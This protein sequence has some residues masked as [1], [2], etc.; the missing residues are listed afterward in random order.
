MAKE[1]SPF[2]NL[3]QALVSLIERY[4]PFNIRYFKA[5]VGIMMTLLLSTVLILGWL[6]SRKV[7]EIVTE[8]FNQQQLVLVRH[9]A[10][11]IENS[12]NV[13]K[14]ELMLLSLSPAIQYPESPF[15]DNRMEIAFSSIKHE[16][17]ME[18]RFVEDKSL[19]T[20]HVLENQK[21][22]TEP[23]DTEDKHYVEWARSEKNKDN[24]Y[25]TDVSP[26]QHMD[27]S[28]KLLMKMILPVWQI[29]VNESHPE[30]PDKFF[31]VLIFVID[32][33]KL[34]EG[35]TKGIR[36]GKTGYSWVIDENGTFLYHQEST[37]IGK[38]AFE[39]RKGKKPTISF[40]RI[41]EIQKEKMLK[42]EEGTSWY[43]SGWHRGVE[44]E[45]KKLIA[46][47]P[48]KLANAG[49]RIWSVAVVAPISEVEGAIHDI[50]IR[51]FLL[52]GIVIF[53]IL[54][55][56]VLIIGMMLRWS[57][58]LK[59]EVEEKTKELRKSEEQYRSLVEHAGDIIFT[60]NKEDKLSSMNRY[61][62]NF[63]KKRPEE[64]LGCNII[65]LF[66]DEC[67]ELQMEKIKEV[68]ATNI[69]TQITCPVE[70]NGNRYWLST[71]Y[72]GLLDENG[73]VFSVLGISRDITDRKKMEETSY[74]TEKLASMGTLAAGVA[75]EINN[76]LGIIL[77]FTDM[78]LE[79]A[80]PGSQEHDI[81][82]TMERHGLRAKRV[83]ENLLSFA[84]YSECKEEHVD[85]N[86]SIS[87]VL[88]VVEH[89]LLLNKIS[90]KQQMQDNLPE[91]KGCSE[92]LQQVFFNIMNNAASAMKGGG[93]LTITT[94]IL[95]DN[96]HIEIR[97][98]DTGHGIK[99]EYRR[100]IFDPL[101]TT[102][103]VGE[104][105]GL[106]LSVSYGI[107]TKHGGTIT[108]E[109]KTKEESEETGTTFIITLPAV[110]AGNSQ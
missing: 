72:N 82:T 83:V 32:V 88:T 38:N 66:P 80:D 93:V 13:L 99:K 21:C 23:P 51:Q 9:A 43:I 97:F 25:L 30:A 57:G 20:H 14:R 62:Y 61:G 33:N 47:S 31:G 54:S 22:H 40:A 24:I 12:L 94:R 50:Q 100:K 2:L 101:F 10:S 105:T 92:E 26:V 37:F 77:G 3:R 34:I 53:A 75:H 29:S 64:I 109:T 79:K 76:P 95:S 81:L 58:S 36:S 15:M 16:G 52:E 103:G 18:I 67:A 7:R 55:G 110:K 68:F 5:F 98:S 86:E 1:K 91:V 73:N 84:R 70:V 71:N 27:K 87:A 28:Q 90:I 39:A 106:G 65:E 17:T 78:L 44:G 104:G 49:N 6:S 107:V 85:I 8:D 102:K 42:G 19:K 60:V 69:S 45:I 63:F 4:H 48:I 41:N 89:T 56:G 59:S 74:H 46:Y 11:Q 96:R 108:F 35:I